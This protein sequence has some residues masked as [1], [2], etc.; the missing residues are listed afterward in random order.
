MRLRGVKLG[1]TDAE[2]GLLGGRSGC[3]SWAPWSARS[4]LAASGVTPRRERARVGWVGFL[5]S[6]FHRGLDLDQLRLEVSGQFHDA[7]E[8]DL[9]EW[10]GGGLVCGAEVRATQFGRLGSFGYLLY[11]DGEA[12]SGLVWGRWRLR[13]CFHRVRVPGDWRCGKCG[14]IVVSGFVIGLCGRGGVGVFARFGVFVFEFFGGP[15]QVVA[16]EPLADGALHA[17]VVA[18]VLG[19]VPLVFEDL[20][21]LLEEEGPEF[22]CG[23]VRGDFRGRTFAVAVLVLVEDG[24]DELQKLGDFGGEVDGWGG[25]DCALGGDCERAALGDVYLGDDRDVPAAA[26]A[27]LA[28][29]VVNAGQ[30]VFGDGDRN[31]GLFRRTLFYGIWHGELAFFWV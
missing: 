3:L 24:D 7:Q 4:V 16:L 14:A 29:A 9:E 17:D 23:D 19:A 28:G 6:V 31:G 26:Q 2:M 12:G 27:D 21:A 22:G 30:E 25:L 18:G 10:V 1:V 8:D 15:D 11:C 5:L 20:V 13:F